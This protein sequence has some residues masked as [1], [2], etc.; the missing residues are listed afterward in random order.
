MT[1]TAQLW[2]HCTGDTGQWARTP[3]SPLCHLLLWDR[4]SCD[5]L[6]GGPDRSGRCWDFSVRRGDGGSTHQTRSRVPHRVRD[7]ASCVRLQPPGR[8]KSASAGGPAAQ[9]LGA[10]W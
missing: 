10:Q 1:P 6:F 4:G 2:G 7:G 3:L 5:S 8:S 9:A